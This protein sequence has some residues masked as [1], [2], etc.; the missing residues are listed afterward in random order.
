MSIK[1]IC[2]AVAGGMALCTPHPAFKLYAV[3][4]K[5]LDEAGHPIQGASVTVAREPWL[6][7][8]ILLRSILARIQ[9]EDNR[10]R[11]DVKYLTNEKGIVKYNIRS[12]F[13]PGGIVEKEG[14]YKGYLGATKEQVLLR[15]IRN[16][17]PL[18]Y[19]RFREI[20]WPVSWDEPVG[21]D[22]LRYDW[23][24]PHGNGEHEDLQFLATLKPDV[25]LEKNGGLLTLTFTGEHNGFIPIEDSQLLTE[26]TFIFPYTAPQDGYEN[27][28]LVV[29]KR[30]AVIDERKQNHFFRIRTELDEQGNVVSA[31][32][33]R[34]EN[35][36]YWVTAIRD[37]KINFYYLLNPTPNDNNLEWDGKTNLLPP[38]PRR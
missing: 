29:D 17:I 38:P 3:R 33:G 26:S 35:L 7:T 5:V 16:P 11:V 14:Y 24:P 23:M 10:N 27:T 4:A 12:Y 30:N 9:I 20:K 31:L 32:Y 18:I 6:H 1:T 37:R 13:S 25:E 36:E 34:M 8:R 22:M 19:T 28:S 15:E 21:F 2:L